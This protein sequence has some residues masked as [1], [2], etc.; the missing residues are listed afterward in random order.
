MKR[1]HPGHDDGN[2]DPKARKS[3]DVANRRAVEANESQPVAGE[4]NQIQETRWPEIDFGSE[5]S[6]EH[7]HFVPT[8]NNHAES[9]HGGSASTSAPTI[10]EEEVMLREWQI[11]MPPD[12]TSNHT[13][14]L[15]CNAIGFN[16]DVSLGMP[17]FRALDHLGYQVQPIL[18]APLP[19]QTSRPYIPDGLSSKDV[20]YL[21]D[22]W[23]PSAA[24]TAR[25]Y[26]LY[27]THVSQFVPFLHRPTFDATETAPHLGLSMLCLAYQYGEDPDRGD[28]PGSGEELSLRCFHRA[29]VSAAMEEE[30]D[31]DLSQKVTLVQAYWLLQVFLMFYHCEEDSAIG[32]KMHSKVISLTRFG[33]LTRPDV[34]EVTSTEDLEALWHEFI[35]AESHKRTLLAVHQ[36][37]AL[38]YQLFSIPRSLSHLEIKHD[39]P[40]QESCW[41]AVSSAQWAHRQLAARQSAPLIPY[42]DAIRCILSPTPSIET[43]PLFDL[44][45]AINITQF[46]LSSAREVSGW[47]TMTG[48]LSLERFEP[49]QS[50]LVAIERVV[51][52]HSQVIKSSHSASCEATWE[53]AMIELLIWSPSHTCGIVGGSVLAFLNQSTYLASSCKSLYETAT[54][55]A[56]QPHLDWF[57]RYLDSPNAADSELPWITLY[58]YKA[59]L[60]AW[61]LVREGLPGAMSVVGVQDGDVQQATRWARRAFGRS[62]QRRIAVLIGECLNMLDGL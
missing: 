36:I 1:K 43:L 39:L 55:S 50:S 48:R 46:L 32:S 18:S 37:D 5:V 16:D 58:A 35:R 25:G 54:N 57:L 59:F 38:W 8:T 22:K 56:V 34:V 29:R 23:S 20:P 44:Y 17:N 45:G 11:Q 52:P 40:C 61:Q 26:H 10:S 3:R 9:D 62:R 4:H 42:S 60:I 6:P 7:E 21:E 24:Q 15:E 33:G 30:I 41:T 28:E 31:G 49:L 19:E 27:F 14:D 47:S 2:G 12:S 53:M 51:R 13:H